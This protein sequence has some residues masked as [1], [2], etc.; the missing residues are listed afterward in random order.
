MKLLKSL[1]VLI[2]FLAATLQ[3]GPSGFITGKVIDSEN[4]LSLPGA[5]V[6]VVDE[7]K[8]S[9]TDLDGFFTIA[10]LEAG[11]YQLSVQYIGYEEFTTDVSVEAG[12]GT[13]INIILK[14]GV[15]SGEE[16]MVVGERLK[17][18]ARA[19]NVQKNNPN[20][21]NIIASDQVGKFPDA[22]IGDAMKRIPG[23]NVEYDQGE[24]R[25]GAI[26][27]TEARLNSVMIN[28]DRVPSAEG[29]VRAVQLDLIPSDMIKVIEVNKAVTP[30]MEADAIGG[31]VNLVTHT[32]PSEQRISAMLGSG[33][34]FLTGKPMITGSFLGGKRFMDG[35]LGLMFSGSYHDHDLGSHNI[36]AEWDEDDNGNAFMSEFQVRTYLV[37][38][39]RQSIATTLDY[40]LS[41]AHK[42]IFKAMYNHRNDFENRFRIEY[43]DLEPDASGVT[44]ESEI[45]R[46]TK[47]GSGDNDNRRLEDQRTASFALKGEHLF[48]NKL[49]FDWKATYAQASEERPNER[50]ISLK[51]EEV[52]ID[53]DISD[54][55]NPSVSFV[56]SSDTDLSTWELDEMTEEH[57]W[58]KEKDM[59][60]KA[61]LLYPILEGSKKSSLKL[62]FRMKMKNKERDNKFYEYSPMDEDGFMTQINNNLDDKTD[63]D[64]LAGDY[65]AGHFISEEFLGDL[66]FQNAS[67]FEKESKPDEFVPAN[68]NADETIT[69]GYAMYEQNVGAKLS[70]I[71]GIRVE[72]TSID[73]EGNELFVDFDEVTEDETITTKKVTGDDSYTN[74]LPG[75]HSTYKLDENTNIRFAW[76][77]TIARPN[78]YDLVPFRE[79][80]IED[81]ELKEGNPNLEPTK[82]MN[83]DLM[84]EKFFKSVG[85]VSAG[86]F[87]KDISKFIFEYTMQDYADPVTG[88]TFEEYSHPENGG[89]ATL[90]GIEFA[91]QRQLDFLPAMFKG[92]GVYL[93]YT[94]NHSSIDGLP[95]EGR[96]NEDLPLPGTAEHTFNASLS[97][98]TKKLTLRGSMS[99]SSDF[100]EAGEVGKS[101]FYDRYYDKATHVDFNGSYAVTQKFRLF[102]EANNLTN[103]PLRY[104]QGV[105]ERTMQAEYYDRRFTVGLKYDM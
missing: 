69:A 47:G 26:R 75:L 16:V 13:E 105:S 40:K 35:K 2:I 52:Q 54:T 103:Q 14:A 99:Y 23:F 32:S 11:S 62:G 79:V 87:Y 82:S 70:F 48:M 57:Q 71:A 45:V 66:N 37:H 42:F 72:N 34:N 25:F 96:E 36:E 9:S 76:T 38:R 10:N 56:N 68:Y 94:W 95:I 101:S 67:Q 89:D 63:D 83:I 46:E 15:I 74:I 97:Y 77:N 85:L 6:K 100:I 20:I 43:K 18:Q 12:T 73:Y 27:G 7:D 51:K 104:Y 49:K 102:F 29:E 5:N 92:I 93:N 98:E 84:G 65:A 86:F 90:Y 30:D 50:Y 78:Y 19:L 28:G 55:E 4:G 59:N 61:D 44:Q 22:N 91:V 3:A 21:S 60:F 53:Q 41:S 31:A 88:R 24:A 33:Y 64:F 39:I 17:G 1:F 81:M 58:T 80:V 8:G